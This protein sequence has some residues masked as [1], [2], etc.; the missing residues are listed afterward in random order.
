M[1]EKANILVIGTS[2][3]GKSTLINTVIGEPKA[4]VGNGKHITEEMQAYESE[5][6]GF[7]LIDSRGFE[8]SER[9]TKKAVKD[10]KK[11]VKTGLQDP[12]SMIHMMWFCID[13]TS[14]RISKQTIRTMEKVKKAWPNVPILVVLTK[15][16]FPAE[17]EENIAMV[18]LNIAKFAKNTG[19]PIAYIPVLSEAPKDSNIIAR[20]I[21]KLVA[22]TEENL[23]EA[24][25]ASDEVINKYVLK[26]KRIKAQVATAGATTTAA[27][28]GAVPIPIHDAMVLTPLEIT[29]I[30]GIAKI[31]DFDKD[32][33]YTHNVILRIV[34]SGAV[35]V[36]AKTIVN[37][38]KLLPGVG[39]IAAD[40]INA[41]VAGAVVL[42]I[43]ESASLI[44]EKIYLGDID[45][46]DLEWVDKIVDE[47]MGDVVNRISEAME[48]NK[49]KTTA[50]EI[51]KEVSRK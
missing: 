46:E 3:A 10:M 1:Q 42:A 2:G 6:L 8:Y 28:V 32:E 26:S 25:K 33:E 19:D 9:N 16:F 21:E 37:M 48:K 39:N 45:S 41:I 17:D 7:R 14:K 29:L 43:G 27:I 49:G 50:T 15:S 4:K 23:P 51:L 24:V 44:F 36:A 22:I 31:Y 47:N 35:G 34:G 20:G 11:W 38:L 12:D 5:D 30:N 40:I 13:A 18:K